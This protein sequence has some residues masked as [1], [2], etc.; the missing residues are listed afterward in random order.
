[1]SPTTAAIVSVVVLV[2]LFLMRMPVAYVMGL[3]GLLGFSYVASVGGG[4][5]L[6]ARDL[7][8]LFSSYSLSVIPMFIFMGTIAFYSG[9]SGRLFDVAYKFF[10]HRRGGLCLATIW[11]CA[12]FGAIC[13]STN[14]AAAAMGKVTLP[15]MK[16]YKYDPALATGCVA[17]AGSLAILI[18]PSTILIIYGILTEESIGKLF[19]AGILPGLLLSTLFAITVYIQCRFTPALAPA[20]PKATW[21]ER[22]ASLPGVISVL[23]LFCFVMAGLFIGWFTPSEAGA[24]GSAGA[25][26]I[27]LL[28]RTLTWR[29]FLNALADTTLISAMVFLIVAGGTIYGH[30]LA[31]TRLPFELSAWVGG[32]P[33]HPNMIMG[34][35][36]IGYIIG[37]CFMD[38]LAMITFT[39]PIL[40]P[41]VKTL[42]FHPIWFGVIVVLVCEMGAIS[43]P[44]GI[45]VYVIRGVAPDVPMETIFR[46]AYPFLIA[47]MVCSF[48][49]L[50][51]PQIVLFLPSFIT[52]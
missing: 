15:E 45:N 5:S 28:G 39:I 50:A 23:L 47:L 21:K 1:M 37:G 31:I 20:G 10:G 34:L 30:F 32:L 22:I 42:G 8:S 33:F 29:G 6:L 35:I 52:Y 19:A 9:M 26:I 46:G 12:A 18:P 13:G 3:V 11:A 49:L 51:L 48:L 44:V 24:A 17:S 43:P 16:K 41:L 7:W 2:F 14:A 36:I 4:L 40:Y 27:A 38:S 25:L